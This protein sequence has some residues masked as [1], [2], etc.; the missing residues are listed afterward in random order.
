MLSS[1]SNSVG[2]FMADDDFRQF[3][4]DVTPLHDDRA[5]AGKK[6]ATV[7]YALRRAAAV[8]EQ[9]ADNPLADAIELL[10]PHALVGF[11]RPGIQE[12]V[13]KKLR[14]GRYESQARLDLHGMTVDQARQAVQCFVE[15]CLRYELRVVIIVHGKGDRGGQQAVLKSHV[16]HWLV[17]LPQVSAFHSAQPQHGGAGALYLLLRKSDEAK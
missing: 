6:P 13:Y 8:S 4:R 15:D 11:K 12:G 17:Q 16:V 10:D 5:D 9:Q 3:V 14:L 7:D 2:W 1:F